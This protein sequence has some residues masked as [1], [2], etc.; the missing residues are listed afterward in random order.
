MYGDLRSA[1]HEYPVL[2]DLQP[3]LVLPAE[4]SIEIHVRMS[5]DWKLTHLEGSWQNGVDMP[6]SPLGLAVVFMHLAGLGY[7]VYSQ[8]INRDWYMCCSEFSLLRLTAGE[9][10]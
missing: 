8:D 6:H 10:Q 7:A 3:G 4:I 1:G 9:G 5:A 2:A